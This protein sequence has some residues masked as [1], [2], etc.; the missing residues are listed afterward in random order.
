MKSLLILFHC[1]SNTGYAIATLER[2]FFQMA[3]RL[4]DD[5]ISRIHF[6][7]PTMQS[8]P[9][10]TLPE[11]LRQY[12]VIDANS[13]DRDHWCAVGEY[14]RQHEV[15]LLFGFDQPVHQPIY[16]HFRRAGVKHFISY[17]GASMSSLNR[18]PMRYLKRAEVLCRING[19]DHYIF[20]S[21]GMADLAVL[22][23]GV[24][25]Q[26]V[27]MV[28]LGVDYRRFKPDSI[29]AYYVYEEL[30]IPKE[31]RIFF[32]SGHME[33]RKGIAVIMEAANRLA[34]RRAARDWHILL[35]GN[36]EHQSAPYER[37]LT[38]TAREHVTFGGYRSDL[39][40]LHRGCY[41]AVIASNGWDSLTA[42]GLEVQAS[43]LP[44]IV[45]DLPGL[46]EVVEDGVSGIV[47]KA[48]D[49][50]DLANAIQGLLDDPRKRDQLGM[51]A[52]RRI[53]DRFTEERQVSGLVDVVTRVIQP[54]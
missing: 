33:P 23:R 13:R 28:P 48:G 6:A 54:R 11:R 50:A 2:I 51:Q 7:Y 18:W 43:G 17:W 19:P 14:L 47:V 38:A 4:C 44:L 34:D 37:I 24:P 42:S 49:A 36:R 29:D 25:R 41:A 20:E 46:R 35:C 16:R 26:R 5:D 45:S 30:A 15:D 39:E 9:S 32:Y 22:G 53:E 52:R 10:R 31:R 27:S 12:T 21:Q 40:R 8:G 3:C 1:R